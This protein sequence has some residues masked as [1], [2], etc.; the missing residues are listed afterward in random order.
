V[1]ETEVLDRRQ[2][3]HQTEILVDDPDALSVVLVERPEV[4]VAPTKAHTGA[5]IGLDVPGEQL[6]QRG[7]A[8]AVL[9]D[10]RVNLARA[11]LQMGM[12]ERD[13]PRICLRETFDVENERGARIT[14]GPLSIDQLGRHRPAPERGAGGMVFD[15]VFVSLPRG[16]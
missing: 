13:L 2:G 7:L 4:D 14:P 8:R 9:A 6:D 11:N 10:E 16:P 5:M 12:V 1:S 3:G 15:T